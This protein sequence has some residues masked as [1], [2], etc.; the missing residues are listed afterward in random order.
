MKKYLLIATLIAAGLAASSTLQAAAA[1]NAP[2]I[3]TPAPPFALKD[4][5]GKVHSLA[6]Y[7]GKVTVIAFLSAKCPVSKDYNGRVKALAMDYQNVAFLAINANSDEPAALIRTHAKTNGFDFPILKDESGQTADLYGAVRTPEV[8]IVDANGVLRYHGRI[9]NSR[10]LAGVKRN[11]V[12]EALTELLAGKPV[13]MPETKAFGCLI[14]RKG[15]AAKAMASQ[16]SPSAAKVALI[17]PAGLTKLIAEAKG[18]VL[19]VNFWAT[20]CAPCVAEFPEF[21]A[22]DA[23]YRD[24][25]L[26]VVG[27]SA[28]EVG[29]LQSKVV[30]FVKEQNV[31]FEIFVQDVE[32][33][34]IMIDLIDK[35][36]EGALPAT[37][38]YD[39]LGKLS[40]VRYGIIDREQMTI[41]IE[42]ALKK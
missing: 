29:D 32:D 18:Q 7:R 39:R 20:W 41:V 23:K 5:S 17:N 6:D 12:R 30:P 42:S 22:F 14:T 25:G 31:R 15:G 37:F 21:V 19:L 40:F 16:K 33:P 1:F 28:D 4:L 24:K 8:Y 10:T 2:A 27:I 35:N 3:N 26:R 36:W 13:S 34:Q 38:V 9:D 11:D